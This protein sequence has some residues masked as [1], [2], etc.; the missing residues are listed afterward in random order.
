MPFKHNFSDAESGILLAMYEEANGFYDSYTI[1]WKLNPGVKVGTP[2]A[3][4]DSKSLTASTSKNS[5]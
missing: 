4:N 3:E 5:S 2:D 1:T